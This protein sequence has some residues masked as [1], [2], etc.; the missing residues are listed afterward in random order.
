ME[1]MQQFNHLK[2]QL[3]PQ[4]KIIV[5]RIW[6]VKE[7]YSWHI[8]KRSTELHENC[9][10]AI[11]DRAEYK[12]T[13][14]GQNLADAPVGILFSIISLWLF[15]VTYLSFLQIS[16]V[17]ETTSKWQILRSVTMDTGQ[18]S[19]NHS[20]NPVYALINILNASSR[21]AYGRA[22]E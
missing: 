17:Y 7:W 9:N 1:N 11:W 14:R 12:T 22:V 6:V 15:M 21:A 19:C 4:E 3:C 16:K 20:C 18:C 5:F 10:S 8:L 13:P 2:N